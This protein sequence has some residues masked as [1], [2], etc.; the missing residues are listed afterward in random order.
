MKGF[1]I[2]LYFCIHYIQNTFLC[3]NNSDVNSDQLAY[4]IQKVICIHKI[5]TI[6]I[7]IKLNH[8]FI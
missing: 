8:Y 6:E 7:R 1:K 2:H 4:H 5:P 3:T